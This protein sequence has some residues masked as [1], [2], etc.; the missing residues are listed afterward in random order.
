ML[1]LTR[2]PKPDQNEI[3]I[4][5]DIKIV[6]CSVEGNQVKVGINAPKHVDIIRPDANIKNVN[7]NR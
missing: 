3:L 5:N 6:I 2:R 4:G 7:G 1:I